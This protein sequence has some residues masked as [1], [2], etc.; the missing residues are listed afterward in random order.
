MKKFLLLLFPLYAFADTTIIYDGK[1][2]KLAGVANESDA[3]LTP[4]EL[5]RAS[6]FELKPQGACL[7]D[8]CVP[9]PKSRQA[10]FFRGTGK[11]RRFNLSELARVLKQPEV[12]D[13]DLSIHLFGPRP[14][15]A[16]KYQETLEAPNFTLPD[17][18]GQARSLR[19][20]RGKKV[21][22]LTWASW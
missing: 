22:L 10:A 17:W 4:I 11:S 6:G 15:V 3:W 14:D 8:L 1:V 18:R 5:T 16:G 7:G 20:F 13:K 21:L 12:F 2:S 9:L 19:D